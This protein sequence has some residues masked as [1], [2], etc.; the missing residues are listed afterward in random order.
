MNARIL[1]LVVLVAVLAIT[2]NPTA[3]GQSVVYKPL[4]GWR[5]PAVESFN[6][7]EVEREVRAAHSI[8]PEGRPT[9]AG[10]RPKN[11]ELL[12]DAL[13]RKHPKLLGGSPTKA[14]NLIVR[15][16]QN[17]PAQLRGIMAEAVFA[18]Q[19]PDWR[20]VRKPNA[21]QHDLYRLRLGMPPETVQVKFHM[22]GNPAT[23]AADM[24]K[25]HLAHRFAV[26][27]DHV[28]P[29]KNYLRLK[30]ERLAAAGDDAAA[31][32]LWRDY[33][34]VRGIGKGSDYIASTTKGAASTE[35][36]EINA[37]YTSFGAAIALSL[38]PTL[39]DWANGGVPANQAMYRATRSLS[40]LGV[41]VGTDFVL[42]TVQ[43]GALRGTLKGNVIVA[44][45]T[46]VT[47]VTWLVYDY[48][49]QRAFYQPQFYEDVVGGVSGTALGFAGFL[50][51]TALASETGPLAPVIGTGVGIVTGTIGYVGGK[52]GTRMI[53]EIVSPKMLQ[54]RELAQLASV[55]AS[56]STA[57]SQAQHWPPH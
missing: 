57:I 40:V 6:R 16:Y 5:D 56:I 53:L 55:Q 39:W 24:V 43:E 32:R 35:A 44:A 11:V 45:A 51:G 19:N 17:D 38:G 3:R 33:G 21:P 22:D 30:A 9:L 28:G 18:D 48:G 26:P 42:A 20:Y 52:A 2:W 49:W 31:A 34:R 47:E 15:R 25:D 12:E 7:W 1:R 36:R 13:L 10:L 37:T 50:G 46:T 14:R 8:F 4:G 41:G 54:Q 27:D 23:Y 29:L